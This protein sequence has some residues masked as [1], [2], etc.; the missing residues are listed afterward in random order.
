VYTVFSLLGKNIERVKKKQSY[1]G[2]TPSVMSTKNTVM[3]G[4]AGTFVQESVGIG[5]NDDR[6]QNGKIRV[7][8]SQKMA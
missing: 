4:K 3:Y 8:G 6:S 2:S 1:Y 7:G 5:G